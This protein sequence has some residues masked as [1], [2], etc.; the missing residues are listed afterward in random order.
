MY[1]VIVVDDEIWS[2]IG[3]RKILEPYAEFFEIVCETTN[4]IEAMEQICAQHPDVV[5]T[6]VRMPEISGLELMHKVREAGIRT[7][8]IVISGFAEFSYVQQAMREGA[9]DYQL[10]PFDKNAMKT[11]L[12]KLLQKL[13]KQQEEKDLELYLQLRDKKKMEKRL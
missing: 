13:E 8:F 5:F 2:L 11:M 4:P 1:R 3:M 6:D 12:E 9:T 10:K 7:E